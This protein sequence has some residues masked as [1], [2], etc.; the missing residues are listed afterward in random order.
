MRVHMSGPRS[1]YRNRDD[2]TSF[3]YIKLDVTLHGR[4]VPL[5][6]E[7]IV[8]NDGGS[9]K[10][11]RRMYWIDTDA[12]PGWDSD[13]E[14]TGFLKAVHLNILPQDWSSSTEGRLQA[15]QAEV[16]ARDITAATLRKLHAPP[17]A[18]GELCQECGNRY[19]CATLRIMD[20]QETST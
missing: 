9:Y 17:A 19:P 3:P 5:P 15:A 16:R 4:E 1:S 7:I 20:A 6:G 12:E 8:L 14:G 18:D 10:V 13:V 11:E 2:E